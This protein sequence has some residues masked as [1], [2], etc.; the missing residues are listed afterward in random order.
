MGGTILRKKLPSSKKTTNLKTAKAHSNKTTSRKEKELDQGKEQGK[1]SSGQIV[2]SSDSS[3]DDESIPPIPSQS[4]QKAANTSP[5]AT[6][7]TVNDS[8][9]NSKLEGNSYPVRRSSPRFLL[10]V[11]TVNAA[12]AML[13]ASTVNINQA[14][15][16]E[17]SNLLNRARAPTVNT[18]LAIKEAM[19]HETTTRAVSSYL[20]TRTPSTDNRA[21]EHTLDETYEMEQKSTKRIRGETFTE[22][23]ETVLCMAFASATIDSVNG[24]DQSG[25]ALW[26]NV[27][28]LAYRYPKLSR[29]LVFAL[30]EMILFRHMHPK[31]QCRTM[32]E[33]LIFGRFVQIE[34]EISSTAP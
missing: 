29:L 2:F 10:K 6:H 28:S 5:E 34:D 26:D 12:Q 7:N 17:A 20:L 9:G 21:K 33:P 11:P 14:M 3:S 30:G 32:N 23:E 15:T 16:Q 4:T 1:V 13:K 31:I 24:T 22:L 18:A 19:I 25:K 27:D 8:P